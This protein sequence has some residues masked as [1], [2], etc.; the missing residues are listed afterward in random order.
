[1]VTCLI[2]EMRCVNKAANYDK[3]RVV[4]QKRNKNPAMFLGRLTKTPQRYTHIDP[5]SCEGQ[6]LLG[7]HFISQSA[8]YIKR[9]L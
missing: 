6:I 4:T 3:I 8:P 7:T 9:K 1:M 2:K 5:D